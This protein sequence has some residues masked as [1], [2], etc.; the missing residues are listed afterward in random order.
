MQLQ[1]DPT[2]LHGA[3]GGERWPAGGLIHGLPFSQLKRTPSRH[4]VVLIDVPRVAGPYSG[5]QELLQG[6]LVLGLIH[7][8][9]FYIQQLL[10]M[11]WMLYMIWMRITLEPVAG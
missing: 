4:H 8:V 9:K 2:Q 6:E 7:K 3:A 10:E 11:L 5:T 1:V